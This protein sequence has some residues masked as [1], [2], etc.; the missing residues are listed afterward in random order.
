MSKTTSTTTAPDLVEATARADFVERY[1]RPDLGPLCIVI[2][3][4]REAQTVG[5]VIAELPRE[6][7]GLRVSCLVVDDGSADGTAESARAVGAY[8]CVLPAN[9]GQGTALRLGYQIATEHGARY[10]VTTDADGQYDPAEIPALVR[11]IIAGEADFVSGSRALGATYRGDRF[12][13]LGVTVYAM[14]I[15]LLTGAPITDPSFGQRAMRV[16]VPE[17][18]TLRQPQ[19][20]ASELLIG[21]AMGGFRV[22]ER[23]GTIRARK[24]GASRKG[25]DLVYGA[26]FG[27]V[28]V[29]TWWRE[30]RGR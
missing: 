9:R 12:R 6:V 13:R 5:A 20:Q 14:V 16:E 18:V 26:R 4:Y 24:A 7:D 30:R 2:A 27:W 22:S 10:L 1:G 25:P 8:V 21:A 19:F 23:P 11:P 17:S 3:A 28:V 29:T 15:R